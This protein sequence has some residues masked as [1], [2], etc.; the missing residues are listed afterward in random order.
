VVTA[1]RAV[2]CPSAQLYDA[3]G[4]TD[5]VT[6][7]TEPRIAARVWAALGDARTFALASAAASCWV[8]DA[9][10]AGGCREYGRR[11]IGLAGCEQRLERRAD[12]GRA[13]VQLAGH[14]CREHIVALLPRRRLGADSLRIAWLLG[15]RHG[16]GGGDGLPACCLTAAIAATAAAASVSTA[17]AVASS[18]WSGCAREYSWVL[19]SDQGNRR[20]SGWP[21]ALLNAT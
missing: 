3:T 4:A 16:L 2:S 15:S 11:S 21:K 12:P 18:L 13:E 10:R 8:L 19:S 1:G 17:A 7:R 14:R 20:D 9:E 5:T 6:R